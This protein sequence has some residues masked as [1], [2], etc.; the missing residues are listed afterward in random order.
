MLKCVGA[1]VWTARKNNMKK[2]QNNSARASA[3]QITLSVALMSVAA[4]LFASSF[5]AAAPAAPSQPQ[6]TIAAM[7]GDPRALPQLPA[8]PPQQDGFYP[9]L[10]GA[11]VPTTTTSP[12]V[13]LPSDFWDTTIPIATVFTEPVTT[14]FLD[15]SQNW[16]SLQGCFTYDPAVVSFSRHDCAGSWNYHRLGPFCH[17]Y[18]RT[19]CA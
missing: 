19:R 2:R 9:P 13:A 17:R 7:T 15:P 14:T 16:T 10:P 6:S 4:I 18:R 11:D 8:T 3:L 5:R 12:L 1:E